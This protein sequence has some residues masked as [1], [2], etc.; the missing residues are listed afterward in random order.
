[1]VHLA[2]TGVKRNAQKVLVEKSEV[3]MPLVRLTHTWVNVKEDVKSDSKF[4][5]SSSGSRQR[6]VGG[7]GLV[8]TATKFGVAQKAATFLA[9]S[10]RLGRA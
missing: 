3:K 5:W 4:S 6:P 8:K 10:C 1:M 2:R 7:G 9:G